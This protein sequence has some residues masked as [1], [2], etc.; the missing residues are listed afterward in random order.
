VQDFDPNAVLSSC[1]WGKD[2][3]SLKVENLPKAPPP[4][5]QI[6]LS[7]TAMDAD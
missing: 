1:E 6:E 5:G 4:R 7:L 3:Y 2:D